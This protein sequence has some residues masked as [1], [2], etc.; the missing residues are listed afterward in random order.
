MTLNT[1]MSV[2]KDCVTYERA[3]P[4]HTYTSQRDTDQ[5]E[6]DYSAGLPRESRW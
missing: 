4:F 5:V 3:N 6:E 2:V 1:I